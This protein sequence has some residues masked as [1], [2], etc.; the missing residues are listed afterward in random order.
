M[1]C[2]G[3]II[4]LDPTVQEIDGDNEQLWDRYRK[5]EPTSIQ[6]Y[7]FCYWHVCTVDSRS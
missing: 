3:T 1:R 7:D 2:L 4:T 5:V 6:Q